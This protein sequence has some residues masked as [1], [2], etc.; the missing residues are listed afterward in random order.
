[1]SILERALVKYSYKSTRG[2]ALLKML[3]AGAKEFGRTEESSQRILPAE[4][5]SALIGDQS[6]GAPPASGA[7][8]GGGPPGAPPGGPPPMAGGGLPPGQAPPG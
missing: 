6:T 5:K 7:P 4:L 1:M 3:Q 2:R 8:P